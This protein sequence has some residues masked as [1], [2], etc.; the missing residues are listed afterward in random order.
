MGNNSRKTIAILGATSHI[1]NGLIYGFHRKGESMLH[2]FARSLDRVH[3][4]LAT[5]RCRD[6]VAVMH[7]ESFF[8]SECDIVIN[9]VGIGDPGKLRGAEASIFRLTE[10]YDNLI[11]D[12]LDSH[13]GAFYIN[14]SSGAVYGTEFARPADASTRYSVDANN[15]TV[16]EYY[17]VA[18]LNAELK[19]RAF[20]KLNIVDL[21]IFSYFSRFIDPQSKFLLTKILSCIKKKQTFETGPDNIIRDYA[22]RDDLLSLIEASTSRKTLNDAFDVY[23]LKPISKFEILDFFS[24]QYGLKYTVK[25]VAQGASPT[26]SKNHY[27]SINRKAEKIGYSPRFTSLDC[28]IQEAKAILE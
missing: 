5:I 7:L 20:T 2:L 9:C 1:A 12:Y 14:V 3:D 25:D 19:H 13:P 26:G 11:L 4:F 23:S 24:R 27:Y 17:G 18:K 15:I 21:R 6:H 22:H 10:N 28:I 16:P 8:E